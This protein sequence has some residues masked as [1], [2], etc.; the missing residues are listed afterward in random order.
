MIERE[1]CA[2]SWMLDKTGT[3]NT[4]LL[5]HGEILQQEQISSIRG[6]LGEVLQVCRVM[7]VRKEEGMTRLLYENANGISNRMG[8]NNKLSKAK[9]LIDKLGADI[10]AYNKHRQNLHHIDHCNGWNQLFKGGEADVAQW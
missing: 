7:P 3:I 2:H 10:V 8:G 5:N 9:D 1:D 4:C 6:V